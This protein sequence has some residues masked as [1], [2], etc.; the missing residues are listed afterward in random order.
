MYRRKICDTPYQRKLRWS[1]LQIQNFP[2]IYGKLPWN[3]NEI[4]EI[5]Y[6]YRVT[7]I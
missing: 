6:N 1:L 7:E 2:V 3:R 4:N 5:L